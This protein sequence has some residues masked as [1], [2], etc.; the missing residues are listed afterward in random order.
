MRKTL[1]LRFES[2]ADQ[3]AFARVLSKRGIAHCVGKFLPDVIVKLHS[4]DEL[5]WLQATVPGNV[6]VM[7]DIQFHPM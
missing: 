2:E 7:E 6:K 5:E 3:A 1:I 4:G